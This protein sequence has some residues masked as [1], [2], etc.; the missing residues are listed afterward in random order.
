MNPALL[1]FKVYSN[2]ANLFETYIKHP[3]I[4]KLLKSDEKFDV[5]V[6]EIFASDA[7]L[8]YFEVRFRKMKIL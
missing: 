2:G 5:C 1:S 4:V 8:V 7:F 3:E 6:I